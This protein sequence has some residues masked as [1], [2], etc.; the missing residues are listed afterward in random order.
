MPVPRVALVLLVV[1]LE[2]ILTEIIR[3]VAPYRMNVIGVVLRIVELDQKRGAMQS[4][5]VPLPRL[6]AAG[7]REM[8]F[9]KSSRLNSRQ[10]L[11]CQLG[12]Q[13]VSIILHQRH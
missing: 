9:L 12:P 2:Q 10:I 4:V 7:P 6:G 13:T 8:D 1:R 11:I 5:I 3:R